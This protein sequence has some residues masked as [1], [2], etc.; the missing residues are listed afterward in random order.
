MIGIRLVLVDM[1][2]RVFGSYS[3][4]TPKNAAGGERLASCKDD[5]GTPH[6]RAVYNY[7]QYNVSSVI[8]LVHEK[9]AVSFPAAHDKAWL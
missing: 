4:A 9:R 8:A 2:N 6:Q 7:C 3:T 5:C 1:D